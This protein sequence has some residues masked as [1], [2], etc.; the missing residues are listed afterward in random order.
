MSAVAESPPQTVTPPPPV[1]LPEATLRAAVEAGA[2]S[3]RSPLAILA[4]TS[5]LD[6]EALAAA[7]AAALRY[8]FLP[9]A[10]LMGLAPA[11]ELL[12]PGEAAKRGCVVVRKRQKLIAVIGDP[13][14]TALRSWLEFRVPQDID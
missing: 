12:G 6:G 4:E 11:F 14:D 2:A 5:G 1:M 7:V 3:S 9:S 13:F 10:K 8:P